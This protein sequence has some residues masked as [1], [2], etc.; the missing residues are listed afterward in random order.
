[1]KNARKPVQR[2]P[3]DP[4]QERYPGGPDVTRLKAEWQMSVA[5]RDASY[6]TRLRV[7]YQ[8]RFNLRDNKSWDGRKWRSKRNKKPFPWPGCSDID[9]NLIDKYVREDVALLMKVWKTQRIAVRPTK[10]GR[11]AG[12]ANQV[13]GLLRWMLYSNI[14]ESEAETELLANMVLER[15]SAAL[16]IWWE[17]TEQLQ[18]D[19]IRLEQIEAAAQNAQQ[20]MAQG[21]QGEALQLQA[22]LPALVQDPTREDDAVTLIGAALGDNVAMKPARLRQVIRDLRD[23]GEAKFPRSVVVRDRPTI[24]ALALNEDIILPPEVCDVQKTRVAFIRERLSETDL[25]ERVRSMG[26]DQDWVDRVIETQRGKFR[27]EMLG[28]RRSGLSGG[29]WGT[30]RDNELKLFEIV[31]AYERLYDADGIPGIYLTT[32]HPGLKEEESVANHM[33]LEYAH[34]QMPFVVFSLERRSRLI[35]DSRGY[36]ERAFSLQDSIKRQWDSRLDRTDVATLPPFFHPTG[37]EPEAWGPGV[38]LPTDMPDRYGYFESPRYDPGSK[39]MEIT[40]RE[41]ADEYFGRARENN[42]VEAATLKGEL[43]RTWLLGWWQSATQLLKL[44]QQ[45][46]PDEV[47]YTVVGGA[48]QAR[49]LRATRDEIQGEFHLQLVFNS[50]DLDPEFVKEKLTLIER[51]LQ[52]DVD[53]RIDRGEALKSVFALIDPTYAETLIRPGEAASLAQ[54]EDEQTTLLKLISGIPVDVKGNEAFALRKSALIKTIQMSPVIQQI[55]QRSEPAREQVDRRLKQLDFN[56]E[57]RMVNPQVGRLLGTRPAGMDTP[58]AT[59]VA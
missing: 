8:A 19:C 28:R 42:Q 55:L 47:F 2:P 43:V 37:E 16:G 7:N 12:W 5:H 15:G 33:L 4:R 26:W 53:G 58:A 35:D 21:E 31:T 34:G 3:A 11:D 1:M 59:P 39:E 48:E 45:Y 52:M 29:N 38:K 14:E 23:T 36:G 25:Q 24:R 41:F 6:W 32:F 13:T 57:Q 20:R 56:I 49:P 17:R 18:R 50:Q 10:P 44:C 51:A 40:V 46:L 54:I 27:S 22:Q 9:V 30:G